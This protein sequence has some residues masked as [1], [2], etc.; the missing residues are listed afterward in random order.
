MK[1][2]L[3]LALALTLA[4]SVCP[5]LALNYSGNWG[6]E[7]TFE[8]YAEVRENGPAEMNALNPR[9]NYEIHPVM[10]NYPGDTTY[11]YRSADMYGRNAA[12]R[13]NTNIAVF[14]DKSFAS[15]DEALAY[16][17]ELGLVD[18]IEEAIGSIILVTPSNPE[19]GFTAA[20]QQYYYAL[21]TAIFAQGAGV[22]SPEK[23]V[24]YLDPVY[25]GG[26][27]F[28]YVIGLDGGATF[29]NNY[30]AGVTDYVSR[31]A[32]ML[33]INGKMD[34]IRTV[35][36]EVPVYLVNAPE[37]VVKKY[38]AANGADVFTQVPGKKT[39]YNHEFPLRKVV[40]VEEEAPDYAALVHDAYYTLFIKAQR[41]QALLQ[42]LVSASSPYQG[43]S[44]DQAPYSLFE[45]SA[46]INGKTEDGIYL[47]K[48]VEDRFN[49]I[50][51]AN[52]EYLQTWFEYLPEEIVNGTAKEHSIPLV[53][54]NHGGGDDPRQ[55]VDGNGL[56]V[57]AG[58]K[59]LAMVAPEHQSLGYGNGREDATGSITC[60]CLPALVRY[61]LD[62]YPAL[63]PSRVYVTGYSM[64]AGATM[65][66]LYGDASLF[67]A[68]VP[69]AVGNVKI[70]ESKYEQFKDIDLPILMTCSEYDLSYLYV[71]N[72]DTTTF[73][74]AYYEML[75]RFLPFNGI[76][77]EEKVGELDF[78]KNP[79]SGFAGD[80][81]S[82]KVLNGEY[83]N[84]TW[85]FNND[86][87]VPM[88]GVSY[89]ECLVHALYPEYANMFWDFAKHYTRNP[90]TLEISYN[91]YVD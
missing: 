79:I 48:H 55:F 77:Y 67:A 88:V 74:P 57:L 7:S 16:L 69:M 25:Y 60:D 63:D 41:A 64:G 45:R 31:I 29:L 30:V 1:K 17:K 73:G 49:N 89:T 66:A 51:N 87:G 23:S 84:Y 36:T 14:T 58:K 10:A 2:F 47:F 85:M 59:R 43:Y 46:I 15:K 13:I 81:F 52:G 72:P 38:E 33:L 26:Y 54:T 20:D 11:I 18:I 82:Y 75:S 19:A 70:E 53:L 76:S 61:M 6:N 35:A 24:T 68:A 9:V 37:A 62:T 65:R 86:A 34:R 50:Q 22:R 39:T 12:V 3:A 90:E 8:T 32:G 40:T 4:L 56:L 5:A 80:S 42:G 44:D 27:S 21:Q 28:Y 78:D 71:F 91:P 83:G